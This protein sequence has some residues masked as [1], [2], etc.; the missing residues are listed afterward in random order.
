MPPS[1]SP[2]SPAS[3]GSSP[4]RTTAAP[5]PRSP[6]GRQGQVHDLRQGGARARVGPVVHVPAADRRA[7]RRGREGDRLRD[8]L[9]HRRADQ[10]AEPITITPSGVH[11]NGQ[12]AFD[13]APTDLAGDAR[14]RAVRGPQP[15][16]RASARLSL[17]AKVDVGRNTVVWSDPQQPTD[18]A[19]GRLIRPGHYVV[20][21][22]LP[23]YDTP[24]WS[25]STCCPD[26]T[27]TTRRHVHA[28]RSSAS[29]GWPPGRTRTRW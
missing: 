21:A 8:L 14:Q 13:P 5:P 3:T 6:R 12:L 19:G 17:T 2:A 11:F 15:R 1:R 10:R 29:C 7:G 28:A 27:M 20:A 25:R 23:G 18:A 9:G 16:P 22:S 24:T 4:V 26:T